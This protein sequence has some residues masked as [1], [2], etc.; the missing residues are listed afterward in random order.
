VKRSIASEAPGAGPLVERLVAVD[1]SAGHPWP[2]RLAAGKAT[3]RDLADAVH[4]LSMLHGHRPG[5]ADAARTRDAQPEA[6]DWLAL[7]ADAFAGE[8]AALAALVAAAGPLP[9]TPGHAESEATIL[10][11]RHAL[12]MLAR[13]DRRGC[14]SGAVAALL[15]DWPAV[16]RVIDQAA[17]AFGVAPAPSPLPDAARTDAAIARLGTAPGSERAIGFGAQQLLAQHRGLWSLLEARAEARD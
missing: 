4:A 10:A 3:R 8:R 11:Q 17:A 6:A 9:S 1:G 15:L 5:M 7:V 16:R 2:T 13:S 12:E 14:A